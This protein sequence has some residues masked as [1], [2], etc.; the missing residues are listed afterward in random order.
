V[1]SLGVLSCVALIAYLPPSSWVR[2]AVWL[3]VGLV[4]YA[5]YGFRRAR[6]GALRRD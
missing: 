4:V 3:L 6:L 1:P 5:S 2:F